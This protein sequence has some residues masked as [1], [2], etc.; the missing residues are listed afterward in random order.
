MKA[1]HEAVDR[2]NR[3]IARL[4]EMENPPTDQATQAINDFRRV[5]QMAKSVPEL[6]NAANRY[7]EEIEELVNQVQQV[8]NHLTQQLTR[9]QVEAIACDPQTP[10]AVSRQY[11]RVLVTARMMER[12][13][14]QSFPGQRI[15]RERILFIKHSDGLKIYV[16]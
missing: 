9:A 8:P 2:A 13:E 10:D 7:A 11:M 3:A 12:G 15:P 16:D 14:D 6:I 1:Y 4:S 5:C